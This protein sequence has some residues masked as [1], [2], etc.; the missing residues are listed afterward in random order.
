MANYVFPITAKVRH[1]GQDKKDPSKGTVVTPSKSVATDAGHS[2]RPGEERTI[3]VDSERDLRQLRAVSVL[4]VEVLRD[5]SEERRK[6]Q[7]AQDQKIQAARDRLPDLRQRT[8]DA[9]GRR[10]EL[11]D[12]LSEAK[13][14]LSEAE[15]ADKQ[16]RGE[17]ARAGGSV[18]ALMEQ[19]PS[20]A[21]EVEDLKA[22]H[23]AAAL[24]AAE[25]E[26]HLKGL[27]ESSLQGDIKDAD[28]EISAAEERIEYG[29]QE[30][31][32]ARKRRS[33]LDS[34]ARQYQQNAVYAQEELKRLKKQGWH[35]RQ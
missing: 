27:E 30:R 31:E 21:D 33:E 12:K 11:A 20:I 10:D 1:V 19:A 7:E 15:K 9:A 32:E 13:G 3:R 18:S 5:S 35:E 8:Q 22:K 17:T 2:F 16:Q 24:D 4:D 34:K 29:K 28:A 23:W 25:L 26:V 6:A 14:R